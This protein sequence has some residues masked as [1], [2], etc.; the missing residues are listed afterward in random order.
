MLKKIL[1]IIIFCVYIFSFNSSGYAA[2]AGPVLW[3]GGLVETPIRLTLSDLTLLKQTEATAIDYSSKKKNKIKYSGV[4]LAALLELAKLQKGKAAD[5][6][7]RYAYALKNTY[8]IAVSVKNTEG[9]QLILSLGEI[10]L[11]DKKSV[12]VALQKGKSKESAFT[13]LI[14]TNSQSQR[15][16]LKNI[17]SVDVFRIPRLT[18]KSESAANKAQYILNGYDNKKIQISEVFAKYKI[19]TINL[20]D[21]SS[22]KKEAISYKGILVRDFVKEAMIKNDATSVINFISNDGYSAAISY[23]EL[24]GNAGKRMIISSSGKD[25]A[26]KYDLIVPDDSGKSRWVRDIKAV[27]IA[28]L[29]Q[30][31]MIYVVG[32]GCGDKDLLTSEAISYIGRA[33]VFICMEAY[34]KTM[35]GYIAGKPILFDPFMQLGKFYKKKHPGISDEEADKKAREIYKQDMEMIRKALDEGKIIALLEPGDPTLFGG[36]RNW[37]SPNFP[38]E[39]IKVIPGISSFNVANAM[40]GD[41]NLTN[42]SV[43]ITEPESLKTNESIIESA[44]KSGDVMV[45]FMGLDRM[46]KLM[47]QFNKYYS[48]D[49]P[50]YLIFYAGIDGQERMIKTS[51]EKLIED[52][53]SHKESF[54]GLIY[55]GNNLNLK[56]DSGNTRKF[57]S[58][59][60]KEKD[61]K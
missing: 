42:G 17:I 46:N 31:P 57:V 60:L 55:I 45:I 56:E 6:F 12:V 58:D 4:P 29:K 32:V 15:N 25:N 2:D 44:A 3:I 53:D 30:K 38:K 34:K 51:L 10:M 43:I 1:F 35:A 19:N 28:D 40:L 47:A 22:R 13:E 33:D 61:K 18:S 7:D 16:S 21:N 24:N 26:V 11:Q 9:K 41:I 20:K 8:D 14:L 37:L 50:A 59:K 52:M 27:E 36:W 5:E 39:K 54:L 23:R 49:T 48:K